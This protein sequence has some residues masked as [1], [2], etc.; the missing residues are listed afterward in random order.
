MLLTVMHKFRSW[1]WTR[2]YRAGRSITQFIALDVRR[3]VEIVDA[4]RAAAGVLS[5]RTRTWNVLYAVK[6]IA[7]QPPFGDVREVAIADLWQWSGEPW[8]GPVPAST[9]RVS[10][11]PTLKPSA[12]RA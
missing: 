6:G 2:R 8:G 10:N 4:S 11:R 7:A 3:E 1:Y 9:D 5:V 12:G